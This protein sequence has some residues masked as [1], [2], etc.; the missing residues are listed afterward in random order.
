[1]AIFNSHFYVF[2][3]VPIKPPV[4]YG[5]P[6]VQHQR[7]PSMVQDTFHDEPLLVQMQLLTAIA[8]RNEVRC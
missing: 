1:M 8:P 3:R 2:Q 7:Q 6:M 4:S 5:F